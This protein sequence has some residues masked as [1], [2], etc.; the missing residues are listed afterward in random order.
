MTSFKC[1]K[2]KQSLGEAFGLEH[3]RKNV[4]TEN[5]NGLT[6]GF[7]IFITIPL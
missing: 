4:F 5:I 2:L 7:E 1:I 3:G 6:P